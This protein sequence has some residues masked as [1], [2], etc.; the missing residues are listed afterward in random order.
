MLL[1]VLTDVAFADTGQDPN[2]KISWRAWPAEVGQIHPKSL[3][4]YSLRQAA[5]HDEPLFFHELPRVHVRVRHHI[6]VEARV[7]SRFEYC[8]SRQFTFV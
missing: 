8:H 2:L 7:I 4:Q 1:V 5:T 6:N 3:S